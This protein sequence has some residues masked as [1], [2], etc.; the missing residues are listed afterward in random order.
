MVSQ[1]PAD[2]AAQLAEIRL[3]F[4]G[5]WTSVVTGDRTPY[6]TGLVDDVELLP[7]DRGIVVHFSL[8][9]HPTL[10]F[11]HRFPPHGP[12]HFDALAL[13]E[14]VETGALDA[15]LRGGL[16]PDEGGFVWVHF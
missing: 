11:A 5:G 16:V 10:R 4:S 2:L 14:Y 12:G 7:D 8:A 6:L 15:A 1:D 9:A 13:K 3:A